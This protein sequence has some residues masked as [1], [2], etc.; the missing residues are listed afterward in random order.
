MVIWSLNSKFAE[1]M[2][3]ELF[4]PLISFLAVGNIMAFSNPGQSATITYQDIAGGTL[5]T[6][7]CP[8]TLIANNNICGVEIAL[9]P[10]TVD[11]AHGFAVA[12][13]TPYNPVT[14]NNS[15]SPISEDFTFDQTQNWVFPASNEYNFVP[16]GSLNIDAVAAVPEPQPVSMIGLLSALSLG[17]LFNRKVQNK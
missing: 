5:P 12:F 10:I 3:Y 7:V 9:L 14:L 4:L 15:T 6:V 13:T 11:I 1:C 17:A 16:G 2:K 8:R